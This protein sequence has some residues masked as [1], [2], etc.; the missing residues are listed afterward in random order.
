MFRR[1]IAA[2]FSPEEGDR[3]MRLVEWFLAGLALVAAGFLAFIR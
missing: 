1:T 2:A 3:S